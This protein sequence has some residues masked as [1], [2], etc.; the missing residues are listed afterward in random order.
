MSGSTGRMIYEMKKVFEMKGIDTFIAC[1]HGINDRNDHL[2]SIGNPVD[3]KIHSLKSRV[4]GYQCS[5]SIFQ[6]YKLID[7]IKHIAPDI[8]HL[9]N[10]HSNYLNL[11]ILLKFL[12]KADI[13]TVQTLHDCWNFTGKCTHYTRNKCFRWME[14]CGCCPNLKGD[15][16]SWFFDRTNKM[17]INKADGYSM[18]PRLGVVGVSN[19]ILNESQKSFFKTAKIRTCIYNWIDLDLFRHY[20]G[21][22]YIVK[23]GLESKFVI[24]GVANSWH[25]NKG[26]D[27]FLE[28]SGC[29]G[30][31]E[32]IV[33]VG[34]MGN[35][36]LPS[37]IIS[38]PSTNSLD[39]L[40]KYYSMADVFMQLSL[41]ESFGKV[42]AE[43]MAC[44]IPVISVDSTANSE[45]INERCGVL[46]P[47]NSI[48]AI[49][50]ACNHIKDRSTSEYRL[51]CRRIVEQNF[52]MSKQIDKYIEVYERLIGES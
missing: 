35:R 20:S 33:L 22:D 16:P 43:A 27:T 45:L 46:I 41:E 50:A 11:S 31:N 9:H 23:Y 6:T 42:V 8:V 51:N 52:N 39:E 15:I 48:D 34:N 18:I 37:N 13:P 38:I 28:L 30:E 1:A 25:T 36:E 49:V 12:A 19:W 26:L 10:L 14:G 47:P 2:Y 17:L 44:G 21:R 32:V 24:L 40:V 29:L 7:Y 3:W 5:G 4:T